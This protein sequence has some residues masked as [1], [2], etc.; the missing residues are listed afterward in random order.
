[1]LLNSLGGATVCCENHHSC[2]SLS[3][4]TCNLLNSMYMTSSSLQFLP[5]F[6]V[7]LFLPVAG[8]PIILPS[9][10]FFRR[11]SYVR[12]CPRQ[13]CFRRQ[14]LPKILLVSFTLCSTSTFVTSSFQL[15]CFI[16]LQIHI[17]KVSNSF[18][19]LSANDNVQSTPSLRLGLCFVW[20]SVLFLNT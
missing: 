14:M 7:H 19:I 8:F 15:T 6:S 17:S 1:V 16:L 9:N 13:L 4:G 2:I 10:I 18:L 5:L 3:T 11:P 20:Y 12:T